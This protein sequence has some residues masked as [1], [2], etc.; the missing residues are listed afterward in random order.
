LRYG[1]E[2]IIIIWQKNYWIK[3][4]LFVGDLFGW[5]WKR[6]R[7]CWDLFGDYV[8]KYREPNYLFG[9]LVEKYNHNLELFNLVSKLWMRKIKAGLLW[10]WEKEI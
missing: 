4:R 3:M 6:G 8:K 1:V 5:W 2:I 9:E 7:Y 10:L